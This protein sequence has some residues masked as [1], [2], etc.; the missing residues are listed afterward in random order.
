LHLLLYSSTFSKSKKIIPAKIRAWLEFELSK[1]SF[2]IKVGDR[3]EERPGMIYGT[4][5]GLNASQKEKEQYAIWDREH[6]E[7][8]NIIKLFKTVHTEYEAFSDGDVGISITATGLNKG[9]LI[10]KLITTIED[11]P[12][13]FI[14]HQ[15]NDLTNDS[16][17]VKN[18]RQT[19]SWYST[20]DW[21]ETWK[22]LRLNYS[23]K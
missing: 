7:R 1:S 20:D 8:E 12:I 3:I 2:H 4:T 11:N 21:Q 17:I 18:L 14:G 23:D 13:V 19:D 6:K 9:Q 10:D 5:L 16:T 15:I 22:L